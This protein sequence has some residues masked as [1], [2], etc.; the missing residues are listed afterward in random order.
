MKSDKSHIPYI[1]SIA[2]F[3]HIYGLGKPLNNELMCMKLENQ[4][5]DRR[6]FMPLYRANFFRIIH[7]TKADLQSLEIDNSKSVVGNSLIFSFPG[8]LESW[9]RHG[10]L[11]GNVIYFTKEFA[12]I[13]LTNRE[14]ESQYP[15]FQANNEQIV[16]ISNDETMILNALSEEMME[17]LTSDNEDKFML[18]KI[19]LKRYI[20]IVKRIYNQKI[21]NTLPELRQEKSLFNKFKQLLDVH[22]QLMSE[23]KEH[24]FPTVALI[25]EKLNMRPNNLNMLIK[26]QTVKTASSYIKDKMLLEIKSHLIHTDLQI[27]EIAFKL[28]FENL[29]YFN[30]FFK[31]QSGYTPLEY[32]RNH[33]IIVSL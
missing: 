1:K 7:F 19:L 25:A 32:R 26:K 20:L 24:R 2:D 22:F 3:F 21:E 16:T 12:E 13:D 9:Q 14:Y 8:K 11:F 27:S 33:K 18:L 17:E 29:P 30:R 10:K 28:G 4:P 6:M 31:K 23:Q 5:D 15:F